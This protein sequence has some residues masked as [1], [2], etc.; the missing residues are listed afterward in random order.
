VLAGLL[1]SAKSIADEGSNMVL[2][3]KA[4]SSFQVYAAGP[5]D[6]RRGIL[7]VHGWWGL[8]DQARSWTDR[9]A[10]LGYRVMAIDLYDGKVATTPDKART[11]MN[12]VKQSEANEKYRAT[13]KA[14]QMPGRKLATIGWSFGGTQAFRASLAAPEYLSATVMFYPFGGLS[15]SLESLGSLNAAMLV[16]RAKQESPATI[17]DTDQFILAAK[18]AGKSIQEYTYNA[19]HGFTNPSAKHHDAQA[20]E[21]AWNLTREFLEGRLK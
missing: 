4:G 2:K 6:A 15:K 11:Y 21:A 14:L 1:V 5:K 13:L 20:T 12:A 10:A 16:I 17:E 7:L 19:K 3:T 18:A 9:F 8:N